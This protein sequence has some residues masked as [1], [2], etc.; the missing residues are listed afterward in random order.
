MPI[1]RV[2]VPLF[3][4][5]ALDYVLPD[6][7]GSPIGRFV[8]VAVGNKRVHGLV[9]D[10]V[11]SS[12]FENK[13]KL[14]KLLDVP[15]LASQSADFYKWVASYT[16]SYPGESL[17]AALPGGRVP[18]VVAPTL[19]YV[20]TGKNPK[21]MTEARQKVLDASVKNIP[22]T[23]AGLARKAG[24]SPAVVKGLIEQGC[25]APQDIVT[26]TP[27]YAELA[28]QAPVLSA[29][30]STAAQTITSAMEGRQYRTFLLDGVTG[31]GKTE[32]Y[33]EC[34]EQQL[35]QAEGQCLIMV[36]E[37]SLTPQ[38]LDRFERRF[39]FKPDI[40][41]SSVAD[42]ARRK[43]WWRALNG[44]ARVVIGARSALFLPFKDLRLIVVDEEHDGSYKQEEVFR[45]NGR[46]MAIVRGRLAAAPVVLA[47]ATPSLES[48]YNTLEGRYQLLHLPERH[49]DAE[50]PDVHII[51][52]KQNTSGADKFLSPPLIA[53]MAERLE[54][55]EQVMLFLN[56]RGYAPLL[57]CRGC[58]HRFS[59]PSCE[60]SLVVHGQRMVCHHCGFTEHVPETCP[61]CES[62]NL[63]AFG[64]GT[65]KVIQ[66]VMQA[67]PTVRA[68]VADRDSVRNDKEM[69][70]IV[71]RMEDGQLDV[72]VGTQ[73]IAKGHHFPNLT[74]VGVV[75]ADMG[76]AQ[77][78]LRAAERTFQLLTQVSGRAGR[79][80]KPGEVLLQ[81]HTPEHPL[82]AALK[83][84]DR[85]AF[86]AL[87]L[88]SRKSGHFPPFGR[89]VALILSGEREGDVVHCG[90][91]LARQFPTEEGL[92]LFGPAPAPLA[93]LRDKYRYRLLVRSEKPAHSVVR[94]WLSTTPVPKQV[95]VDIDVDP[96]SFY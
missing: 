76:L 9:T 65:R 51:D 80:D 33:F 62:E 44:E 79:A 83:A 91:L 35:K 88:K 34:I 92:T 73:M 3:L 67:F 87:E 13:L 78:D 95:R 58:G 29:G 93:R 70:E 23:Q 32:V 5:K 71:T 52:L 42:G 81:T 59:C 90:Q 31:S 49:G 15:P 47:S 75:D 48:W 56:R 30:Q 24:V 84:F 72:L 4:P 11:D 20:P 38:W 16:M 19:G 54:R 21:K 41:H 40:W 60:A 8:E 12:P 25:L 55:G 77:G 82:F 53:A 1:V 69:G 46:D 89:L 61:S 37:I 85:D 94:A 66:E 74:L 63:H 27:R 10:V 17:R 2:T 18:E 7:M 45:Y 36:P 57:L 26:A 86:Y 50:L 14:A 28:G 6:G 68:A 43:T 39:G 96:Q 22:Y 64:P